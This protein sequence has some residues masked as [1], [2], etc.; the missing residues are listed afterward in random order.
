M[1]GESLPGCCPSPHPR[2]WR[3]SPAT[4]SPIVSAQCEAGGGDKMLARQR[5]QGRVDSRV[6]LLDAWSGSRRVY[7][8]VTASVL[9]ASRRSVSAASNDW[10]DPSTRRSVRACGDKRARARTLGCA[11]FRSVAYLLLRRSPRPWL[12]GTPVSPAWNGATSERP[13]SVVG[14]PPDARG[15]GRV[16]RRATA[17]FVYQSGP[18][19]SYASL[20]SAVTPWTA[21]RRW[22][23][24]YPRE[25]GSIVT[26]THRRARCLSAISTG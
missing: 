2:R 4:K 7:A 11:C 19:G 21:A 26:T 25:C 17:A 6:L 13:V 23:G 18:G 16:G 22:A 5:M 20:R 8:G 9:G 10:T 3:H 15:V 12:V 14:G 1:V 24:I